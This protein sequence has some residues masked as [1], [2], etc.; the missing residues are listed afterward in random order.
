MYQ[1]SR[2]QIFIAFDKADS[3]TPTAYSILKK[4]AILRLSV[5]NELFGE[6]WSRIT[7]EP[8]L[9]KTEESSEDSEE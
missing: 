8:K 9:V 7:E 5:G 6:S 1:E 3:S 2:R 4:N